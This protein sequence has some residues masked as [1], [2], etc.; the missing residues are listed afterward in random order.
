[1]YARVVRFFSGIAVIV[2]RRLRKTLE[3]FSLAR[4][5]AF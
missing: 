4:Q 2:N 5:K 3:P 1:V